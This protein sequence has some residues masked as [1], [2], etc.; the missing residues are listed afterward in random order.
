MNLNNIKFNHD[1]NEIKFNRT[2]IEHQYIFEVTKCCGYGE[3]VSLFKK[4]TLSKLYSNIGFQY[5]N[6]PSKLYT[7]CLITN[8][9][10]LIPNTNDILVKDFILNN[11]TFFKPIYPIPMRIVYK[12][13]YTEDRCHLYFH[14]DEQESYCNLCND[15]SI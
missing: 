7:I 9:K 15:T 5:N 8:K 3:W 4:E 2:I 14:N 10:L 13:Y 11:P 6:I 1:E 12:I